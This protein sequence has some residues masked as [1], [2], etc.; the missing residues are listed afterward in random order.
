ML[1]HLGHQST[2]LANKILGK[3]FSLIH[4][5]NLFKVTLVFPSF[6]KKFEVLFWGWGCNMSRNEGQ[7][8]ENVRGQLL[9]NLAELFCDLSFWTLKRQNNLVL[10]TSSPAL[11]M[12]KKRETVTVW[13]LTKKSCNEGCMLK[14]PLVTMMPEW[15]CR[16]YCMHLCTESHYSRVN[17]GGAVFFKHHSEQKWQKIFKILLNNFSDCYIIFD[18]KIV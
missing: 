1:L 9:H 13:E 10:N 14:Q 17:G 8:T 11:M 15:L 6:S 18:F 5:L 3:K 4:F 2:C 12:V 16:F 7:M